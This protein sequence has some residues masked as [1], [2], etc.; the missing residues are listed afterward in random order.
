MNYEEKI[1]Y[2]EPVVIEKRLMQQLIDAGA[3]SGQKFSVD[4][5][6]LDPNVPANLLQQLVFKKFMYN[7]QDFYEDPERLTGLSQLPE[8]EQGQ[9]MEISM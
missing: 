6:P 4:P 1:E 7:K 5:R 3:V 8:Q 2:A 9:G